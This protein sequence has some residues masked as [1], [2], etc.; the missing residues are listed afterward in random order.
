MRDSEHAASLAVT[1]IVIP[2]RLGAS[3]AERRTPQ[4][5]TVRVDI[6]FRHPPPACET[7]RLADTAD[8]GALVTRLVEVLAHAEFRL[9]EHLV[10]RAVAVLRPALPAEAQLAVSATKQPPLAA[11][12]GGATFRLGDWPADA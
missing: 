3:L 5:V 1:G 2:V 6:R 8:Y 10:A 7:D 12:T 9:L 11:V 4:P